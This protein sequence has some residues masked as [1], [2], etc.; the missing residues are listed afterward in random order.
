M[1]KDIYDKDFY[2]SRII[3]FNNQVE[4]YDRVYYK[5]TEDLTD[6]LKIYCLLCFV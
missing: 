3:S 4:G 1:T 2:A 5:T 6:L